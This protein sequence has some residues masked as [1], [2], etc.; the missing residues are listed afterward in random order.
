MIHGPIFTSHIVVLFECKSDFYLTGIRRLNPCSDLAFKDVRVHATAHP[1][2]AR[3]SLGTRVLRHGNPHFF[4]E[5]SPKK[6][7]ALIG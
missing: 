6:I 7:R 4:L 2:C 1:C 3:Y 5:N